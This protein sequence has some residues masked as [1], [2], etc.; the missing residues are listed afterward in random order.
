M[1]VLKFMNSMLYVLV[2]QESLCLQEVEQGYFWKRPC[3][4]KDSFVLKK[5]TP[6][7]SEHGSLF[8]CKG[9]EP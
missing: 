4:K 8:Q 3:A 2:G 1:L 9:L 7:K 6:F 5:K